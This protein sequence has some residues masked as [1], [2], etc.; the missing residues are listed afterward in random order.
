MPSM[1]E[2]APK[3]RIHGDIIIGDCPHLAAVDP[4]FYATEIL[5]VIKVDGEKVWPA[6]EPENPAP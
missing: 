4:I 2:V 3:S 5:G 6:P 1:K